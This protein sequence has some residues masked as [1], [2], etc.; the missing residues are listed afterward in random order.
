MPKG[1][2]ALGQRA[3]ARRAVLLEPNCR[4]GIAVCMIG[5]FSTAESTQIHH[6]GMSKR[7]SGR[8]GEFRI[9]PAERRE[10]WRQKIVRLHLWFSPSLP[11]ATGG[12]VEVGLIGHVHDDGL[13]AGTTAIASQARDREGAAVQTNAMGPDVLTGLGGAVGAGIARGS[14]ARG[15]LARRQRRSVAFAFRRIVSQAPVRPQRYTPRAVAA[16][17]VTRR[18]RV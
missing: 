3:V 5:H 13:G 4:I 11:R 18:R 6:V 1:D 7:S 14:L 8:S 2:S 10:W 16:D 12:P 15:G 17:R 9:E